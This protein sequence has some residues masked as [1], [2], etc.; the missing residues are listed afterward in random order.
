M[1]RPKLDL[2]GRRVGS[3]TAV[4]IVAQRIP[5]KH[6]IW[7]CVCDCGNEVLAT[8]G[9][10]NANNI[11]SCGCLHPG[12]KRTNGQAPD[13]VVDMDGEIWKTCARFPH[14]EVSNMGRVA[15]TKPKRMGGFTITDR[16]E[17]AQFKDPGGRMNVN[18][19]DDAGR[20]WRQKVH[21]F[22]LEAFIGPCPDGLV[23]CHND[24]DS[25]NNRLDNLRWDTQASNQA[26]RIKHG[27]S[28]RG[29]ANGQSK[30]TE[31]DVLA[32]YR[33]KRPLAEIAQ[34]YGMSVCGISNIKTQDTWGW[35]TR[36]LNSERRKNDWRTH[37]AI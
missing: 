23:C 35:L 6:V 32:I 22:V 31:A 36:Q 19:V 29:A 3:L 16:Y 9:N 12:N 17:L 26:D 28:N 10:I 25:T 5:N 15:S 7:R 30:L 37:A 11:K 21:R 20:L 27:T 14:Y 24:G 13:P 8:A 33:D 4:E 34:E 1:G 2:T 18:I